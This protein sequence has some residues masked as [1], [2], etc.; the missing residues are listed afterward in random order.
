[1]KTNG[2]DTNGGTLCGVPGA[3]C[4]SGDWR[5]AYANYLVAYVKFYAE[6][7][8][9]LTHL[10]FLNEPDYTASYASM[11]SNGNQAAD[12]IKVL[13]AT[14]DANNLTD[15]GIN[16]CE[17]MGWGNQVN[18]LNNIKSAGLEGRLKAVTSHSYSSGP[19]GAM[20]TKVPVWLSE[21]CDLNGQWSTAWYSSGGAGDGLTWANNI[22]SAVTNQNIGGYIWWEGAQWPNRE[23]VFSVLLE[24]STG[25][26][27]SGPAAAPDCTHLSS[28]I[29]ADLHLQPTP[30][31]SS[32]ASII[33]PI[34]TR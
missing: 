34:R 2:R 3:T 20:N 16:C 21:Q 24:G 14:L 9:K 15:V 23:S 29:V 13:G 30:T 7:G 27:L 32:F 31:K 8:V 1:M 5:Q 33:A 11:Q 26:T 17:S 18:M 25:W 10:G 6:A 19:S 22:Y 4:S 12:F 28:T